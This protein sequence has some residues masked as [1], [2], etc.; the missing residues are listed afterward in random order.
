[1]AKL[2]LL[3]PSKVCNILGISLATLYREMKKPEFPSKIRISA[4]A[5]GFKESEIIQWIEDKK[6]NERGA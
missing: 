1:M 2:Q 3:R 5:V 6:E 4:K